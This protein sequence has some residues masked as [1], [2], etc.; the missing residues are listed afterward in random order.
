M[1]EYLDIF[2]EH[3]AKFN[4]LRKKKV[5]IEAEMEKVHELAK[6][7]YNL[8]TDD[9]KKSFSDYF[10]SVL[11]RRKGLTEA[12]R[13]VL[14]ANPKGWFGAVQV[15]DRLQESGFNFSNYTSNPL[16][17]IHAVLKRFS[18]SEVRTREV[19][20]GTKKYQWKLRS[21]LS[22]ESDVYKSGMRGN[23]KPRGE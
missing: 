4:D 11:Q 10:K 19:L 22:S 18:E 7:A 1:S 3:R 9:E 2:L 16:S 12:V 5:A 15:R 6:A 13:D 21:S 20:D 14:Q 8:A 23:E 17:S